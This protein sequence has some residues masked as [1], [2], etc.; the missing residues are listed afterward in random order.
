VNGMAAQTKSFQL[1]GI[2]RDGFKR[3]GMVSIGDGIWANH[4]S[5]MRLG[6]HDLEQVIEKL[7]T[8]IIE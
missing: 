7:Q 8:F 5:T 1:A 4:V 2:D 6:L 3:A